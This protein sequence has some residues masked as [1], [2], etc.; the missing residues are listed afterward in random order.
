[1]GMDTLSVAKPKKTE[2]KEQADVDTTEDEADMPKSS[3]FDACTNLSLA[4]NVAIRGSF[5]PQQD[6]MGFQCCHP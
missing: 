4:S 3:Y 2:E 1:M 5:T 6:V